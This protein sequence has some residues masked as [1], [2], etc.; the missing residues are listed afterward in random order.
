[1]IVSFPAIYKNIFTK[2]QPIKPVACRRNNFYC[3]LFSFKVVIRNFFSTNIDLKNCKQT[4]H[5]S[6]KLLT[7]QLLKYKK[8]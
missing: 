6:R 7:G 4:I 1:M 5:E 8:F 2:P 3:K